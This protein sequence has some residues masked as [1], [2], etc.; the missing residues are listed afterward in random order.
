MERNFTIV[1]YDFHPKNTWMVINKKEEVL[2]QG[3][4]HYPYI[5]YY[6]ILWN[7]YHSCEEWIKSGCMADIQENHSNLNCGFRKSM[8][9][10]IRDK[11]YD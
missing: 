4:R 9:E 3:I 8:I 11:S 10:N 7:N 2:C 5:V 1:Q 6:P